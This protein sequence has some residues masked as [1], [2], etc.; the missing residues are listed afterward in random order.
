MKHEELTEIFNKLQYNISIMASDR[1]DDIIEYEYCQ[2]REQLERMLD[3]VI[4]DQQIIKLVKMVN[5][6]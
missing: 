1:H 4:T 2:F 3:E 6:C 5:E